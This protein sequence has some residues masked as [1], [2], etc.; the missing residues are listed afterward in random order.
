MI[1]FDCKSSS[2]LLLAAAAKCE[3]VSL[4]MV[5]NKTQKLQ[6]I[7]K[8]D[9]IDVM[10]ITTFPSSRFRVSHFLTLG[11]GKSVVGGVGPFL[12]LETV[13][14]LRS[15]LQCEIRLNHIQS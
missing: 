3:A 12:Y 2:L 6:K 4:K 9:V 8:L 14:P 15:I 13:L 1:A 5:A 7:T 11:F 10:F